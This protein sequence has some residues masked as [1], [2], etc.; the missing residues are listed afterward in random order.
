[1]KMRTGLA[2]ALAVTALWLAQPAK[3]AEYVMSASADKTTTGPI[4]GSGFF[5]ALRSELAVSGGGS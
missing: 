2:A 5:V 4:S 1:M 3:A